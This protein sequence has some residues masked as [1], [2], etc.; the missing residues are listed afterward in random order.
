MTLEL[1]LYQA[2]SLPTCDQQQR[3]AAFREAA[4]AGWSDANETVAKIVCHEYGFSNIVRC[5][6]WVIVF[7]SKV[8]Q[9]VILELGKD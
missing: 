3:Q 5:K 2:L 8:S 7:I 9:V 6:F 4:I 1:W